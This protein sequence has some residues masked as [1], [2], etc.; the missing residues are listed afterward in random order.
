[1][2]HRAA[3]DVIVEPR[4]YETV[5]VPPVIVGRLPGAFNHPPRGYVDALVMFRSL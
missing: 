5:A 1:M 4:P 2:V 3:D